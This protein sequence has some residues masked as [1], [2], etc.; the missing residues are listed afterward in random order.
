MN[1][2]DLEY[3]L[4]QR[5]DASNNH[6][7]N[8]IAR[9]W[10]K[11]PLKADKSADLED[12]IEM[13]SKIVT[14]TIGKQLGVVFIP[15]EGARILKDDKYTLDNPYILYEVIS[16]EPISELKPSVRQEIIEETEDEINARH[17]TIWGQ[18]FI[19]IVQ[20]N[21]IACDYKTANK[22]MK[23]FEEL[24]FKYTGY[25]KKNGVAEILFKTQ[26]TDQ[27]LDFYR[28][29]CSVRSLQYNI[30]IEKLFVQFKSDINK[31][32]TL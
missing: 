10:D 26:L 13:I 18:K 1:A 30:E 21:I 23:D 11:T 6:I 19:S 25:F 24:I 27:N 14:K 22:V 32:K 8:N 4:Q 31:I 2:T 5:K 17:G 29:S 12:F 28:Q 16:R 20:F 3:M 7:V 9:Q 15:D